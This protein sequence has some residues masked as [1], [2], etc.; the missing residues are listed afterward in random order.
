MESKSVTLIPYDS[1]MAL[2]MGY[3]LA[4]GDVRGQAIDMSEALSVQPPYGN[5]NLPR[6]NDSGEVAKWPH[7][8]VDLE[9]REV[10]EAL[11]EDQKIVFF[12]SVYAPFGRVD[13]SLTFIESRKQ[14]RDT[15]GVDGKIALDTEKVSGSVTGKYANMEVNT[16][17][18]TKVAVTCSVRT[19]VESLDVNKVTIDDANITG[20]GDDKEF[21]G[22]FGSSFVQ[23]IVYGGE[24]TMLMDIK[25]NEGEKKNDIM[26]NGQVEVALGG[27]DK[28]KKEETTQAPAD[29]EKKDSKLEVGLDFNKAVNNMTSGRN[30]TISLNSLG[31]RIVQVPSSPMDFMEVA[32]KFIATVV[33]LDG[34]PA[35][36]RVCVFPYQMLKTWRQRGDITQQLNSGLQD[37]LVD[38]FLDLQELAREISNFQD[39]AYRPDDEVWDERVDALYESNG[40]AIDPKL[41]ASKTK[42]SGTDVYKVTL[43]DGTSFDGCYTKK[44]WRKKKGVRRVAFPGKQDAATE[45]WSFDVK[46]HHIMHLHWLLDMVMRAQTRISRAIKVRKDNKQEELMNQKTA[47]T[48]TRP[49]TIKTEWMT[50]LKTASKDWSLELQIDE[51]T[52]SSY[53]LVTGYVENETT[54]RQSTIPAVLYTVQDI[55]PIPPALFKMHLIDFLTKIKS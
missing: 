49:Y 18:S 37:L 47:D 17:E 20:D 31:G 40:K 32:N 43:K 11:A 34:N 10:T 30:V 51:I 21:V 52:P 46:P 2:G 8:Q 24:L 44:V 4:T 16:E 53:Y 9:G 42:N 54:I 33:G 55:V 50:H 1:R 25:L 26:V 15:M 38:Y 45:L 5:Q 7:G 36:V 28:K 6:V 3:D 14:L 12:D 19:Y 39:A 29:E 48:Y 41:I 35:P 13:F 22:R 27:D 23:A